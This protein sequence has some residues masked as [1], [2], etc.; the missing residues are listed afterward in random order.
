MTA[1]VTGGAEARG[2]RRAEILDAALRCFTRSGYA[3]TSIEDVV[4]ESGASVGSVYHHFGGKEQLAAALYVD[5]MAG[6]QRGL[7]A[8][9][10]ADREDAEAAVKGLVRHHL[11]WVEAN[12]DLARYLLSSREAEVV[13]AS[14][15]D[16]RA[17][18]KRLFAATGRWVESLGDAIRPM[19]FGLLHAVVVGPSQEFARHWLAGR[20]RETIDE[21]E[22]VL[23][24]AAWRGV[25]A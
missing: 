25:R 20:A 11:R 12:P 9:L 6:Y 16:L 13:R 1:A 21:A 14:S 17:M 2:T 18:N 19:P 8:E 10:S 3:R 15:R 24:E 23:A 4:R 22:P 5:G 7:E